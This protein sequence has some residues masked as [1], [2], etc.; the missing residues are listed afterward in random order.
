MELNVRTCT[1]CGKMYKYKGYPI[2]PACIKQM[3]EDYVTA[4]DYLY[5]HPGAGIQELSEETGIDEKV[6]LQ[7][8]RMGRIQFA[9]GADTGVHCSSCGR[10]ITEGTMCESCKRKMS[11][12]LRS[13]LPDSMRNP[14]KNEPID[15]GKS[16]KGR[17]HTDDRRN[18][19]KE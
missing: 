18:R 4:R 17:M 8:V 13:V 6:I 7:M 2:C 14:Q 3:D 1:L 10:P 12:T 11:E 16:L 15:A 5:D 9:E 19:E